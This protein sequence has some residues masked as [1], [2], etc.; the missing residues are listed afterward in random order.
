M[1][2]YRYDKSNFNSS[3]SRRKRTK[4][5][6][7][8][9]IIATIRKNVQQFI[10]FAKA[11]VDNE[12]LKFIV[13]EEYLVDHVKN[14]ELILYDDGLD[15]KGFIIPSKPDAPYA[16]N[17]TDNSVTLEWADAASGT[18]KV[19][20]YKVMY[21]K[22]SGKNEDEKKENWTEVY[23]KTNHKKII[24]SNL[25]SKTTFVFKVQS[26][27]AIGLSAI[28]GLSQPIETLTKKV[29]KLDE[30]ECGG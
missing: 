17:V 23:T 9:R 4:W 12:K 20:K 3:N 14:A 5:F 18:E 21:Q 26:I 1:Y 10:E 30:S 27:T 15:K 29:G 22:Y 16:K 8:R 19:I 11:N 13:D 7:D 2:N 24:I 28:S 6:E 25:P